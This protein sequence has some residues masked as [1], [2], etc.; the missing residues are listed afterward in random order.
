MSS[1]QIGSLP[2]KSKLGSRTLK[3]NLKSHKLYFKLAVGNPRVGHGNMLA[4]PSH[5][6][7]LERRN[8]GILSSGQNVISFPLALYAPVRNSELRYSPQTISSQLCPPRC[9]K[10]FHTHRVIQQHEHSYKV[11]RNAFDSDKKVIC[12]T[13]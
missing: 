13:D 1:L 6:R 4:T 2:S 5:G 10:K 3:T 7:T 11:H 12:T 8:C 9:S